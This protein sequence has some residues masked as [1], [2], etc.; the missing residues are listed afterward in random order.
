MSIP[1]IIFLYIY[2]IILVF[3]IILGFFNVYHL[4]RFSFWDAVS[5]FALFLFLAVMVIGLLFSLF[6]ISQ[7]DWQQKI[8]LNFGNPFAVDSDLFSGQ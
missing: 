5:F 7:I 8:D 3:I 1:L 2:L 6:E 4:M